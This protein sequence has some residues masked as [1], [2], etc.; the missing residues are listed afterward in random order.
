MSVPNRCLSQTNICALCT[1][2]IEEVSTKQMSVPNKFMSSIQLYIEEARKS[3]CPKQSLAP[4]GR[5]GGRRR[6]PI[7]EYLI[8]LMINLK[9]LIYLF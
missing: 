1:F 5:A 9:I 8:I 2:D 4:E 7:C 3:V 6:R